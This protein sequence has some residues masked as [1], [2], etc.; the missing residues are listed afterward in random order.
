MKR[1]V[2]VADNAISLTFWMID[3][4]DSDFFICFSMVLPC[5]IVSDIPLNK[6]DK[7]SLSVAFVGGFKDVERFPSKSVQSNCRRACNMCY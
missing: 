2:I 4:L 5:V 7:Y 6:V 1:G 3:F